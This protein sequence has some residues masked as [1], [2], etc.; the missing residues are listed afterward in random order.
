MARFT[1]KVQIPIEREAVFA[2]LTDPRR[3]QRWFYGTEA[4][5]DVS[6]PLDIAGTTF[7]QRAMKRIERPGAV[8]VAEPPHLWHVR[9]AG[10]GE[11]ADLR[12]ELD[13]RQD[14]TTLSLTADIRNGPVILGPVVDR[15]TWRLDRRIWRRVLEHMQEEIAR[16]ALVP[17]VGGMYVFGG[18][19]RFRVGQVLEADDAYVHVEL[20]PGVARSRPASAD[21]VE[22]QPRR[23]RDYLDTRPLEPTMR[24][25]SALVHA[26]ADSLLADG[27]LGL[28]HMP[29]TIGE[30]R[31]ARAQLL[32]VEPVADDASARVIAWRQRGG[33]AF[34]E[35]RPP[36]VGWLFSVPLQAMGVESIGFGV[37]KLLRQQFRGVHVR[38]YS[39]T[40]VERPRDIDEAALE[41]RPV[42]PSSL[43]EAPLLEPIAIGHLPLSHAAFRAWQPEFIRTALV[44]P[45]ELLG[46]EE[47]KLA[48]GGFF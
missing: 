42:D 35:H 32:V 48:E 40:F 4:I 37:V 45:D 33:T 31:H 19:G 1:I 12:F 38:V 26:G 16:D 14:G 2:A 20:R 39:N 34:G 5:T 46:Y 23:P 8:V 28:A 17:I 44:D 30:F 25:A 36:S 22:L 9:L 3:I 27:G 6:G 10:F 43:G 11:R 24:S 7:V 15:L 41:S 47:W 29:V 21:A 13:D 18:G